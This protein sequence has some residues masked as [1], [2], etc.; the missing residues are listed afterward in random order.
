LKIFIFYEGCGRFGAEKNPPFSLEK[1]VHNEIS[2][3]LNFRGLNFKGV[4]KE[5][6]GISWMEMN[7]LFVLISGVTLN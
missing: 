1:I 7:V 3:R 2:N 6:N 5:I 4:R